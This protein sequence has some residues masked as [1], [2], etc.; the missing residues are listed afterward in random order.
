M[1]AWIII[2]ALLMATPAK[3]ADIAVALTDDFV[4]VDTGFA[5][6]RLVLFGAVTGLENPESVIDI[7]SVVR[8]PD[9]KFSVR[10]IEKRNLI[11]MPGDTHIIESAP[12]LYLTTAT[13]RLTDIAPL[14]D[15]A[16]YRLGADFL[17]I[18][19]GSP[20]DPGAP[21]T[22][23]DHTALFKNA[24]LSEIEDRGLYRGMVG[25]VDFKK[26]GLFTINV[27]LPANTPVGNYDVSVY[28]YRNGELLARDSAQLAV[29]KVG[30]ERRIYELA[31]NRP[32]S[33]GIF[34]V[35]LSLLAGWLAA[36]AFRK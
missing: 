21:P 26:G 35:A 19:A 9:T 8:G 1:R 34:C 30:I 6:A 4:R 12:G 20:A 13:K 23:D 10:Q 2:F 7:V 33:Y 36:L 18:Q 25:G 29:N 32:V 14:P 22:D 16:A 28:L 5:G 15:Q 31:H 24:F 11:W 27:D 17:D 3:S